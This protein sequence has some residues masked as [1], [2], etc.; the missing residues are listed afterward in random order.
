MPKK[1]LLLN[2]TTFD[3]FAAIHKAMRSPAFKPFITKTQGDAIAHGVD[4]TIG[5]P[6]EI[7]LEQRT[8]KGTV[9]VFKGR[10]LAFLIDQRG[11]FSRSRQSGIKT[12]ARRKILVTL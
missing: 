5:F 3:H 9:Y 4:E 1:A 11:A 7:A 6:A 12:T 10:D 8:P 2:T